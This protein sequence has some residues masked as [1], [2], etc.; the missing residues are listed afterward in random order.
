MLG[1]YEKEVRTQILMEE[2]KK[3]R[4]TYSPD[5]SPRESFLWEM[6]HDNMISSYEN[7]LIWIEKVRQGLLKL[8]L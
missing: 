4:K 5:R 6:I 8:S 7:E 2:E 3:R 1:K